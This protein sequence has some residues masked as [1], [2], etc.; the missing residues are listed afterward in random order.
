[1]DLE[2]WRWPVR[3][4]VWVLAFWGVSVTFLPALAQNPPPAP[5]SAETIER[6]R[7]KLR[8]ALN[9]ATPP[10]A[11]APA[12]ALTA[13]SAPPPSSDQ[14]VQRALQNLSALLTNRSGAPPA[15][16]PAPPPSVVAGQPVPDEMRTLD[17]RQKLG[18]GDRVTFRVKED[19]DEP[20]PLVVTDSGEL[21]VPYV[22]RVKALGK[23]CFNLAME[24]KGLLE[25]EYYKR[26][27]VVI[28]IDVLNRSR[29]KVYVMGA[30]RAPGTVEIASDEVFTVSKAILKVGGFADFADKRRVKLVRRGTDGRET[31]PV[32]VNVE[33]I[34][35]KG[36]SEKD[37]AL[38]PDDMIFVD[39]KIINF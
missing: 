21:E 37:V 10:A 17:D 12:P 4:G 20:R 19:R 2:R 31:P 9:P 33:E 35:E 6:A 38:Q 15:V 24:V 14:A 11:P 8:E 7:Q 39:Q 5:P 30:V 22:G 18:V 34:W 36:R 16:S 28:A 32:L 26:A 25:R 29:G 13:E 3:L 1:M 27:T 23:T